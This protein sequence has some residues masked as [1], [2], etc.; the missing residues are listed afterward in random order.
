MIFMNQL[1]KTIKKFAAL[2]NGA[3]LS[4]VL[5]DDETNNLKLENLP[6][7]LYDSGAVVYRGV[8]SYYGWTYR[9][10]NTTL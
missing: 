4:N 6:Y 7:A 3:I 9:T 8:N 2:K 10:K 1:N 5:L